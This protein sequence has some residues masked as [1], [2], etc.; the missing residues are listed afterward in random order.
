MSAQKKSP[1]T[2]KTLEG[3]FALHIE[4]NLATSRFGSN[5]I[6]QIISK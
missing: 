2:A 5:D 1:T 6:F 4:T 3:I